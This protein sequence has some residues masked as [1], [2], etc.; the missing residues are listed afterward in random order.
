MAR[1]EL[2]RSRE[3]FCFQDQVRIL[4][5]QPEEGRLGILYLRK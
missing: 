5:F 1:V 2:W 4:N 3:R